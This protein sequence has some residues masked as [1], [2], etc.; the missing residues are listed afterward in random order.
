MIKP[1]NLSWSNDERM[2]VIADLARQ[3][4]QSGAVKDDEEAYRNVTHIVW[5]A[6]MPKSFL[7]QNQHL[8]LGSGEVA[9]KITYGNEDSNSRR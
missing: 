8:I 3:L 5:I 9:Y 4:L 1:E 2:Y 6:T 7:E